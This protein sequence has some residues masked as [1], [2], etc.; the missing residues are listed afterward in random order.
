MAQRLSNPGVVT[1]ILLLQLI[2]LVIFP[3]STF[4]ITSQEWCLPVL[5]GIMVLAAD[6]Q[7]IIRRSTS[8]APWYLLAFAQGFNFISRL[9]MVWSHATTTAGKVTPANWSYIIIT[10]V[11]MAMSIFMLWYC[12]QP[13]VRM[14]Y[15]EK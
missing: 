5:L 9:M 14:A 11:S 10:L 1:L 12:E 8:L 15:L 7:I 6:F 13:E 2:P 4:K 3:P